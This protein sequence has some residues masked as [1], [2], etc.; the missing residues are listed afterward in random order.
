MA[1]LTKLTRGETFRFSATIPGA[2]AVEVRLRGPQSYD[3]A[4]QNTGGEWVATAATDDWIAGGYVLEAWATLEDA[5]KAIVSRGILN[6]RESGFELG[7]AM[8]AVTNIEAMLAGT[9]SELVREY[10]IN[11]RRL[12]NYSVDELLKLLSFW[13][14]RLNAERRRDMGLST[15]G[16]RIAVRI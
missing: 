16:P 14:N 6:V 1:T 11:N 5:S 3:I 8:Q 15:L 7:I 10:Q 9:A 2:S 12:A 4:A 13:K